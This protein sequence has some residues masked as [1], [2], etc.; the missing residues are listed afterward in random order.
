MTIV[1]KEPAAG[2][3]TAAD[4]ARR[5]APAAKPVATRLA[6]TI[7]TGPSPLPAVARLAAAIGRCDAL[8]LAGTTSTGGADG[9]TDLAAASTPSRSGGMR[10]RM[11]DLLRQFE[12]GAAATGPSPA[13]GDDVSPAVPLSMRTAIVWCGPGAPPHAWIADGR[14]VLGF[15]FP[16]DRH[17]PAAAGGLRECLLGRDST[18]FAILRY[19]AASPQGRM[20]R[21]GSTQT[22]A[23]WTRTRSALEALAVLS[24]VDAL[25]AAAAE[26][27]AET[28]GGSAAPL[29]DRPVDAVEIVRYA[30]TVM[31]RRGLQRW[32]EQRLGT[33]AW[34]VF[35]HRGSWS[36]A[37][38][39][40]AVEV[41]CP[42]DRSFAEPMLA[43]D[44]DT[45][46]TWCFVDETLASTG[47]G[48]IAALEVTDARPRY[49]GPV[50]ERDHPLSFPWVFRW[51]G[52]WYMCPAQPASCEVVLYRAH[53]F[54]GDWRPVRTLLHD[55]VA[56]GT[57]LFPWQGL[58]WLLANVDRDGSGNFASELQAF[59]A[60]SPLA[61]Q[62]TPHP[63]NPLRVDAD[64]GRN[65]GLF[66]HDGMLYR[67]GQVQGF[68][69][70]G[71]ALAI[72]RVDRLD[73]GGYRETRVST[74]A[75][76]ASLGRFGLHHGTQAGGLF[77]FD[78]CA[79]HRYLPDA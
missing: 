35:L 21:S 68:D 77:A 51:D 34:S 79:S 26:P 20:V 19:D 61:D 57:M 44:A 65:G 43:H 12:S 64:G 37:S 8:L 46:R 7:V 59:H 2:A 14:F 71:K 38:T 75:P 56:A 27:A 5:L 45:G 49:H 24:M 10:A 74:L 41:P 3:A 39:M 70:D 32:R 29:R 66:V 72:H 67:C 23:D 60:S 9:V 33:P 22:R 6:V 73:P 28:S 48:R 63:L 16:L 1:L 4:T 25:R 52:H 53:Q 47:R 40:E 11:L 17:D 78:Q 62:W 76:D 36:S 30:G 18:R 58:W 55:T 69:R 13:S 50:L 42:D 31:V 54:P 15:D